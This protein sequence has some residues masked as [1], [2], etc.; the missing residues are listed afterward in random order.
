MSDTTPLRPC[1]LALL[2]TASVFILLPTVPPR[3]DGLLFRTA[4]LF[5]VGEGVPAV[6]VRTVAARRLVSSLQPVLA[7]LP[8]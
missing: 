3:P 5:H 2:T 4:H 6:S 7:A 1:A 8:G